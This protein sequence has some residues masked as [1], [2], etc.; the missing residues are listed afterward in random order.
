MDP[1]PGD[2][3]LFGAIADDV[4]GGADLAGMLA[5][6]GVATVQVFGVPSEALL[7][8][9]RRR[10][11]ACVVSLKSRS[12]AAPDAVRLSIA[13][14][15]SLLRLG[16]RQIQF[17][18]CSTFDSTSAGNIGPVAEA[19]LDALGTRFAVA[20]PAL[21]VNGRTLYLGHLFVDGVLLSES[22][23]RHHPA[24]PMTDS[25]LV[26]HLQ[27]QARRPVGLV[28]LDVVRRGPER[29]AKAFADLESAGTALALVDAIVDEDVAAV[30]QAVAEHRLITGSSALATALPDVWRRDGRLPR[31]TPPVVIQERGPLLFVAGSCSARTREQL[32][33]LEGAG[34][35]SVRVDALRLLTDSAAETARLTAAVG[36][37]LGSRGVALVRS[38]AE[39]E[40]LARAF[41]AAEASGRGAAALRAA[42]EAAAGEVARHAVSARGAR[43]IVVAGGE[44]TGAVLEALGLEA[45]EIGPPLDPGVPLCR[46]VGSAPVTL[47]PKSG[48][49]GAPDLLVR[50]LGRLGPA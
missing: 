49:F 27:A 41:A 14:L 10:F 40:D 34:I 42:V 28:S 35:E 44:T 39:P 6:R 15:D 38:T 22:H 20:V 32:R 47:V 19:L 11:A 45:L 26:R 13:A 33:L 25:N 4:T 9:I 18:Y 36:T 5:E 23:M 31:E 48:N 16:A 37:A 24:T 30:A 43:N 29:I 17:K 46:S 8:H 2:L 3:L 1:A 12:I 21:P 7:Q 50:L